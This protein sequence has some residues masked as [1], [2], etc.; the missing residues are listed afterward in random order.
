MLLSNAHIRYDR[1]SELEHLQQWPSMSKV[2]FIYACQKQ[3]FASHKNELALEQPGDIFNRASNLCTNGEG[4]IAKIVLACLQNNPDWS[5]PRLDTASKCLTH[6]LSAGAVGAVFTQ[7]RADKCRSRAVRT[8]RNKT[9]VFSWWFLGKLGQS[10]KN[11]NLCVV[12]KNV[13]K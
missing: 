13:L 9:S 7:G 3:A 5:P 1:N 2:A 12:K 11:P 6:I 4:W 8:N 10:S